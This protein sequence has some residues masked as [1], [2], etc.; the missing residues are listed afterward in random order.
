MNL[1]FTWDWVENNEYRRNRKTLTLWNTLFWYQEVHRGEKKKSL[2]HSSV[3]SHCKIERTFLHRDAGKRSHF[4]HWLPLLFLYLTNQFST[5]MCSWKAIVLGTRL[6]ADECG[7]AIARKEISLKLSELIYERKSALWLQQVLLL[8]QF[9]LRTASE[10]KTKICYRKRNHYLQ[11]EHKKC[12]CEKTLFL[13]YLH[14]RR[15]HSLQFKENYCYRNNRCFR[16][17][18]HSLPGKQSKRRKLKESLKEFKES[19]FYIIH[20]DNYG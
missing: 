10:N 7:P 6:F 14:K 1:P 3:Q 18:L 12:L 9:N 4:I 15:Y 19:S 11:R 13:I 5:S 2:V 20:T 17:S 16:N 8:P